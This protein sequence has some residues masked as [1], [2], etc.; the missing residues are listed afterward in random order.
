L[1]AAQSLFPRDDGVALM[2]D[3]YEL[4]MAA[5]YFCAGKRERVTFEAFVRVLP[6]DRSFLIAAGLEQFIHYLEHLAFTEEQIRWL[7]AQPVF[8]HVDEGFFE[9][10]RGFRFR[11]DVW[12][13]PEG[14]VVFANEPLVRV[15]AELIEAQLLETYLLTCLNFQTLVA[16]KA[17]RIVLAAGGRDVVDFGSRRAHGPQAGLLAARASI[18]GGCAGTSNVLA[19]RELNVPAVGTQAHSWIMSFADEAEAFARYA[20]I[21]PNNAICLIDTY[22]VLEGARR[23]A[24]LGSR[25]KGVRL[26]SGDIAEDAKRVRRILDEAGCRQARILASGDLNEYVIRELLERGAPIDA[27]GVGTDLVTSRD[28]PALSV[29]YKLVAIEREPGRSTPRTKSSPAKATLGGVKQVFR[30]LDGQGRMIEDVVGL[31]NEALEGE[32]LQQPVMRA[33]Q[34]VAPLPSVRDIAARAAEQISRLPEGLKGLRGRG[35]YP[36]RISEAL[37]AVQPQR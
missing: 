26:D 24:R 9:Y 7:R 17:A 4:T 13:V 3:L 18:I 1:I 16:S 29:V 25:L 8:A 36:V 28:A 21:F 37:R 23:A 22:D 27:F 20:D 5:G 2:T 31:A 32:P 19:A 14:T 15:S 10:L 30:R 33:G 35:D 12:A 34:R 11:G 6:E